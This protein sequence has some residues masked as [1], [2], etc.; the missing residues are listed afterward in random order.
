MVEATDWMTIELHEMT[1]Y[2]TPTIT[3]KLR[4]TG[5]ESPKLMRSFAIQLLARKNI[6][7]GITEMIFSGIGMRIT[8]NDSEFVVAALN[9]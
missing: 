4:R 6:R 2:F 1:W 3:E 7:D 8:K 9:E 5:A